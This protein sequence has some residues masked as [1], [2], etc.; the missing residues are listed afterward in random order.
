MRIIVYHSYMNI[1]GGC[2]TVVHNLIKGVSPLYDVLFLYGDGAVEQ[3]ERMSQ[4]VRCEKYDKDKEYECDLC[5]C[6][7][8]WGGYPETVTAVSGE[9]WQMIHADYGVLKQQGWIYNKWHKTTRHIA[10]G[11]HVKETFEKEYGEKADVIYN[12]LDEV[13]D[14]KP[15][16]KL[17]SAQRLSSEKGYNRMIQLANLLK[18]SGIKFRWTIFAD[19]AH[20]EVDALNMEEI[21][22]MKPRYDIWEYVKEADY[23][24]LLSD[25]EGNPLF[26]NECL[27]YG[28]PVLV[29]DFKSVHESVTDG[30]NGYILNMDLSNLDINKICDNRLKPIEHKPKTTID[31]WIKEIGKPSKKR[32]YKLVKLQ[33]SKIS[34]SDLKE[35]QGRG[36]KTLTELK[37]YLT[38]EG[39]TRLG[40]TDQ[41]EF[42]NWVKQFKL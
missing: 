26:V 7:T 41:I 30:V 9:Y 25:T 35:I 23:G 33:E 28:T 31:T 11:Q 14:V 22:Y 38:S 13:K 34:D 8:S 17:V 24:V 12:I 1:I 37:T 19:T 18:D 21:I 2:E 6:N 32:I 5:I 10:V 20:Y 3:L 16:L 27:Q 42:K 4:F 15:I 36:F 40:P 39:F 29:T